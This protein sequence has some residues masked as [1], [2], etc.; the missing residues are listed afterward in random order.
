MLNEVKVLTPLLIPLTVP[1][2]F[3]DQDREGMDP[4]IWLQAQN[5]DKKFE[6]DIEIMKMLLECIVLLCQRRGMREELRKRKV[7]PVVR[8]LDLKID[9][10]TISAVIY[11]V[12]NFLI[13]DEDPNT[14]I[15]TP[16]LTNGK[17]EEKIYS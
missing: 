15:D 9:N 2:P 10:E 14:P 12:V 1:T 13:Q 3:T 5:P 7:Y 17:L 6:N 11:E 4:T 16:H 8:N